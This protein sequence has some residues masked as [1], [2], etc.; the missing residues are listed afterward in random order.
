MANRTLG[1]YFVLFYIIPIGILCVFGWHENFVF[2]G[3]IALTF[4]LMLM[5][6]VLLA[7][8]ASQ[9]KKCFKPLFYVNVLSLWPGVLLLA[10]SFL[11]LFLSVEMKKVYGVSFRHT[12]VS[13]SQGGLVV[14]LFAL[15]KATLA[16]VFILFLRLLHQSYFP[17]NL[18]RFIA[19]IWAISIFVFPIAAVD[20]LYFLG[21]FCIALFPSTFIS[22]LSW[23]FART[24]PVIVPGVLLVI[25]LG[26]A[27]KVGFSDF[28]SYVNDS[29]MRIV[30]YLQYRNGV[31]L[32]ATLVN[33]SQLDFLTTGWKYGLDT[34]ADMLSFRISS[35][36]GLETDRNPVSNLNVLNFSRIFSGYQYGMDA[37]ASPG[38]L[39]A[40]FYVFPF[41]I[42]FLALF[43]YIRAICLLINGA[44]GSIGNGIIIPAYLVIILFGMLN[45]PVHVF[46]AVGPDLYKVAL[47]ILAMMVG[48]RVKKSTKA[49]EGI[50]E[51]Y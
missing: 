25:A 32:F 38:L 26:I 40:F 48:L 34:S 39:L 46:T 44:F 29:G 37:G 3:E 35:V 18:M 6:V 49:E 12:G 20:V 27:T 43:V 36:L 51:R 42:A 7:A 47:L 2:N 23:S 28:W 14:Q 1:I 19:L 13:L 16:P 5:L 50:G 22:M 9:T 17:G 33:F 45:S 31:F 10:L 21:F 24:I 4:S 41:P 8:Y 30:K 11:F 15:C